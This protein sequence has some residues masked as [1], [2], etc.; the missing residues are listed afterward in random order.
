MKHLLISQSAVNRA[1]RFASADADV[2]EVST[3][4]VCFTDLITSPKDIINDFTSCLATAVM[5]YSPARDCIVNANR[6][7]YRQLCM[8]C[9][10]SLM[11]DHAVLIGPPGFQNTTGWNRVHNTLAVAWEGCGL[12]VRMYAMARAIHCSNPNY[13]VGGRS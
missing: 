7:T 10:G 8:V 13:A 12:I 9:V 11:F 5:S 3:G 2:T 1:T 6:F 4:I